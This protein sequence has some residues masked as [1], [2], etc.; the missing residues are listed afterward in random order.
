MTT[1]VKHLVDAVVRRLP[2]LSRGEAESRHRLVGRPDLWRM[3]RAFQIQFLKERGLEPRH[4]L[5]ELGC[6]TLRGGIPIIEFLDVGRYVGVDVQQDVLDEAWNELT[7]A[8]LAWK[9][10]TL[11]VAPDLS[12]LALDGK[13]D[14][15]W[16]FSVL[17]HMTDPILHD[18][19]A[20]VSDHLEDDGVFYANVNIG[21]GEEGRWRK[22][23]VVTRSLEFYR[24]AGDANALTV[25]DLGPLRDLGHRSG[26]AEQDEQR[27][28]RI[29]KA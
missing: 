16:A 19:F 20:L 3:K 17:I 26:V 11:R 1:P 7:E 15:V 10:P 27:M 24:A 28:L 5:F 14:C 2:F 23:P 25:S 9:Q 29:A 6:G 4:R 18:A 21:V 13:F 12:R 22:F 8:G